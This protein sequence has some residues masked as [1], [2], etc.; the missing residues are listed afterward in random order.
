MNQTYLQLK[1]NILRKLPSKENRERFRKRD[2][3]G[4]K[5]QQ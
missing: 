3:S 2:T 4:W 5:V 1:T